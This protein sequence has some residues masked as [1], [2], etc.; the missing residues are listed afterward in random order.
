[1]HVAAYLIYNLSICRSITLVDCDHT[2]QYNK[3]WKW[4]R[5]SI[6]LCFGYLRVEANL[7]HSI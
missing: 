4:G 2:V 1:M 5:D 7:D 3:R 6:G